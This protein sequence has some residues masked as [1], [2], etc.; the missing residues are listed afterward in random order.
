VD[1]PL[2]RAFIQE[3]PEAS[4]AL[5]RSS[6]A[7]T[8]SKKVRFEEPLTDREIRIIQRGKAQKEFAKSTKKREMRPQNPKRRL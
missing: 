8:L 7:L 1:M 2:K 4:Q 5:R 3:A 6:R